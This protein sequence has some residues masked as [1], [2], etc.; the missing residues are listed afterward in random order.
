MVGKAAK[1]AG[2]VST[3]LGWGDEGELKTAGKGNEK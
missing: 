1:L 3:R 2:E